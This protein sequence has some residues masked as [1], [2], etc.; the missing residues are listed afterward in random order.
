MTIANPSHTI[1]NILNK[2][3]IF[4][5]YFGETS[6]VFGGFHSLANHIKHYTHALVRGQDIVCLPGSYQGMPGDSIAST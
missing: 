4:Q 5:N 6:P 3:I 1:C 2:K